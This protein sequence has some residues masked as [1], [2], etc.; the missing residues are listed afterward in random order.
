MA[1]IWAL[2][3]EKMTSDEKKRWP[4]GRMEYFLLGR[5]VRSLPLP[6][7]KTHLLIEKNAPSDRSPRPITDATL[8]SSANNATLCYHSGSMCCMLYG[9]C[10][11]AIHVYPSSADIWN[12]SWQVKAFSPSHAQKKASSG[13]E[14][15]YFNAKYILWKTSATISMGFHL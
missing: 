10:A 7:F 12:R 15:F 2:W 3:T 9:L 5:L 1:M 11:D 6:P 13:P 4:T 14:S 8:S